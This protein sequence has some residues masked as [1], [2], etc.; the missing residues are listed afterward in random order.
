[1]TQRTILLTGASG[2]FGKILTR[3]FLAAGD[4]VIGTARSPESMA[5]MRDEYAG[6]RFEGMLADLAGPDA[7]AR[8]CSELAER[9]LVPDCLV[10]NARSLAFLKVGDDGIVSRENFVN[11]YVMDVVVPYELTMALANQPGSALTRVVNIGSQYGSA[12]FNLSLYE[13]PDHQAPLHYGVA[14][15]ALVQLTKELAVRLA[16]RDIKVNCVAFGGI[17]GRVDEAFK[18]R[19]ATLC[20]TGRMLKE[21]EVPGPVD[22][23]LSQAAGGITG[24]T[25]MADGGWTLW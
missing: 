12:A 16:P 1:M 7:P 10:N 8:L 21:E 22:M 6:Q 17:D 23:L 11:E 14:K 4:V 25:I 20:P 13:R 19:Y 24:H 18:A 3:H 2:R 9:G 5:R 15:A